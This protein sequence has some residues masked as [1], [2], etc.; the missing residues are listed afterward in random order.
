MIFSEINIEEIKKD[1]F[2]NGHSKV[3][4]FFDKNFLKKITPIILEYQK[5]IE[6]SPNSQINK[7]VEKFFNEKKIK[8]IGSEHNYKKYFLPF[9]LKLFD[10][11]KVN[12]FPIADFYLRVNYHRMKHFYTRWH[13]DTGTFLFHPSEFWNTKSYTIWISLT[14]CNEQNSLEFIKKP[15]PKNKLFNST[16][17]KSPRHGGHLFYETKFNSFNKKTY[18]IKCPA[19][20]AVIFDSLS[21]HRTIKLPSSKFRASCDM[22]F[23]IDN[24][25]KIRSIGFKNKIKRFLFEKFNYK[26]YNF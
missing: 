14:D 11:K 12:K 26:L 13:Q 21:I 3:F 8:K 20:Y 19:G 15:V 16:F 7:E 5:K 24:D 25:N 18:K 4:K 2:Q 6:T 17:I 10:N 23:Y 1:I 9:F 22:R